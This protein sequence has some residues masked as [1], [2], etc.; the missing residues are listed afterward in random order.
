[1]LDG[2]QFLCFKRLMDESAF[3][4]FEL[5]SKSCEVFQICLLGCRSVLWF[6]W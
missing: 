1:M 5:V 6:I 3:P 2:V 4:R